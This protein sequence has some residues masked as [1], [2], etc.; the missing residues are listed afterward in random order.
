MLS[1]AKLKRRHLG[2]YHAD[3]RCR[4]NARGGR[5][6]RLF[7]FAAVALILIPVSKSSAMGAPSAT[8]GDAVFAVGH[9]M[10]RVCLPTPSHHRQSDPPGPATI[11]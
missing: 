11:Y 6:R 3:L 2:R 4:S 7:V 5:D 1:L 10:S 9:C 8:K